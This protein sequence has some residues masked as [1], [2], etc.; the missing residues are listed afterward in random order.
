MIISLII[1][2]IVGVIAG[3]IV[4]GRG[5]GCIGNV[6]IGAVGGWLGNVLVRFLGGYGYNI[7]APLAEFLPAQELVPIV[8]GLIGSVL[9]L[10]VFRTLF[11]RG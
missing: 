3:I 2:G 6:I 5:A 9:L 4:R 1:N 10:L 8:V 7:T 11:G